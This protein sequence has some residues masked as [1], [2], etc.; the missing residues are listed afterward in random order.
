MY[1]LPMALTARDKGQYPV[2]IGTSLALESLMNIHPDTHHRTNRPPIHSFQMFWV[3]VK[4]VLRNL[5]NSVHTDHRFA[6]APEHWTLA[7]IDELAFYKDYCK[8][9]GNGITLHLYTSNYD[10]EHLYPM[11]KLRRDST[12][13]QQHLTAVTEDIV[14][15]LVRD[16]VL[17]DQFPIQ[18][19]KNRIQSNLYLKTL[20]L[21]H[22]AYDLIN[23]YQ[24][25]SLALIESHA[26]GIKPQ[27]KFNTKYYN[28]KDLNFLPFREDL[29]QIF[30]DQT[31]FSPLHA[32][33]RK[34]IIEQAKLDRWTP[35]ST[36]DKIKHSIN[37]LKNPYTR[38][39]VLSILGTTSH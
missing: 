2:S 17:K 18:V 21:T 30:G 24:F 37:K 22:Y 31:L 29:L 14:N 4:T 3:N 12:A 11:A 35:V 33:I 27:A 5:F 16:P 36:K 9:E 7:L 39:I 6:V 28:G 13:R 25:S 23:P 15:H 10:I 8:N 38:E 34:E 26:G 32:N 1:T 19:F 20:M